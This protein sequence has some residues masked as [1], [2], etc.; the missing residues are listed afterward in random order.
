M[1][2]ELSSEVRFARRNSSHRLWQL[3][4]LA[5][6]LTFFIVALVFNVN[7]YPV[8]QGLLAV[9]LLYVCLY[10]TVRYFARREGGVPVFAALCL[11]YAT[12]FAIPIFTSDPQIVLA[13]AE[14]KQLEEAHV[15][16][17]L[18]LALL[19]V[20]GLQFGYYSLLFGKFARRLPTIDLH[21]NEKK[22]VIFC[23]L[24][25]LILPVVS[26]LRS[27]LSE[28]L[29]Q[30]LSAIFTLLQNQ[31]LV[32]IGI[33]G[34][35]VY[36]E[37]GNKWHKLLLYFVV[38]T[39]VW[40]GLSTA[41]LEQAIIPI[42]VLFATKWLYGRKLSLSGIAA[43]I[44]IILFLS[45]VKASFREA[46]WSGA[47][48]QSEDSGSFLDKPFLWIE[49]ATQYWKD[50]LSGERKVAE[51]TSSATSRADLIHQFSHIY[52]L[53]P[54]IIPY[55]Y[56][57]TYSYFGVAFI[58]RIVWPDKP[59]AGSANEYF[60]VTYGIT[61]EEGTKRSTFGVS[62]LGEGYMNFGIPG[63]LL[64]M[65]LQGVILALLQHIFGTAKS[66]AGGQAV[67]LA[68]FVFFLNGVGTSTEIFF[69]NIVQNLFCSCVLLF[70][71]REKP[72]VK[73]LERMRLAE[74]T[75]MQIG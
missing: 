70:W 34:W 33:L 63:V 42:V 28:G 22:A 67:F 71:V 73:R 49:Q 18:L 32:I 26:V 4:V 35:L 8:S 10:P 20:L 53:T 40:R 46:A 66:G 57:S 2:T 17:A 45:P 24:V 60:A 74:S 51:A 75:T 72:S 56:G 6:G 55:Q 1:R 47:I 16:A 64:I 29:S 62:L 44:L 37:R 30:Q 48:E 69:G 27:A 54:E 31:Q 68:F 39:T 5:A 25:G 58:P 11:A 15:V 43:I 14:I 65:A 36:S 38:V 9:V 13:G 41:F 21:L 12:Q 61:T 3:Y 50:T 52:S 23:F 19:G 59:Q 7:D